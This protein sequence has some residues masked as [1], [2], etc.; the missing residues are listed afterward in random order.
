MQLRE[1]LFQKEEVMNNENAIFEISRLKFKG[2]GMILPIPLYSKATKIV[3][4]SL[5][6]LILYKKKPTLYKKI[7]AVFREN[8]V[9]IKKMFIYLFWLYMG[10]KF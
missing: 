7:K 10:E 4:M 6:T 9:A 2:N 8:K 3:L 1:R 5:K